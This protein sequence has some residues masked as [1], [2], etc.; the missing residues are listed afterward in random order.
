MSSAT[1]IGSTGLD[2]RRSPGVDG[3]AADRRDTIG[4]NSIP[5]SATVFAF[6]ADGHEAT[7]TATDSVM[8]TAAVARLCQRKIV[9]DSGRTPVTGRRAFG[10][11]DGVACRRAAEE[12]RPKAHTLP[13]PR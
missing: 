8:R 12:E 5:Y 2:S 9:S 7:A 3:G 1:A 10:M 4:S 11:A 6:G 13:R